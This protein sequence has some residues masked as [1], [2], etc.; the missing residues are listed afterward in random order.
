MITPFGSKAH[1]SIGQRFNTT[2][3]MKENN[4]NTTEKMKE[5]KTMD[6]IHR[7]LLKKFHTLCS[8]LGMSDDE[9]QLLIEAYGVES[10]R[11]IDTHDLVDICGK[12]SAQ[13]GGRKQQ[14][15]DKLRKQCMAAIG[16]WLKM[17]GRES[18]A[19]LIKAI[20]C[21]ATKKTDFNKIPPERLR[22]LVYLFNN[23]VKDHD[24]AD[25]ITTER[26]QVVFLYPT[27]S[28]LNN[29]NRP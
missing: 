24:A 29:M 13:A 20:A 26:K 4:F 10:S 25:D 17:C 5:N 6:E 12:L 23:K 28:G 22:N 2:E 14:C 1:V 9:K 8:V 7:Q 15:Y 27:E 11:D 18:N 16:S 21:R 19:T 3:K